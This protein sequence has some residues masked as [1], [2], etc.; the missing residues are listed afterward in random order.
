MTAATSYQ[1]TLLEL[2]ALQQTHLKVQQ[3]RQGCLPAGLKLHFCAVTPI[4]HRPFPLT[5]RL[6]HVGR[7]VVSLHLLPALTHIVKLCFVLYFRK[8]LCLPAPSSPKAHYSEVEA[9]RKELDAAQRT[10]ASLVSQLDAERSERAV[11]VS[12]LTTQ[13]Q[14]RHTAAAAE[15][16][17]LRENCTAEVTTLR[18][19]CTAE[20]AALREKC[21]TEVAALHESCTS[22]VCGNA[23]G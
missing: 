16:A 7:P 3:V 21:T 9:L 14:Q 2:T 6:T 10:A 4:A 23:E 11:Q 8:F 15:V 1:K 13:L 12:N 22:V 19:K 5:V 20:V 17:L 18:E